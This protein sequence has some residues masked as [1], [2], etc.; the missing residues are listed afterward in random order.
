MSEHHTIIYHVRNDQTGECTAP[1]EV[2]IPMSDAELAITGL[3]REKVKAA[4]REATKGVVRT[5]RRFMGET[6][7]DSRTR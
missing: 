1:T 5:L 7:T 6:P 2:P 4:G 3:I